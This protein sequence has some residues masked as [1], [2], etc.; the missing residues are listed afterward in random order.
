MSGP[1]GL[2]GL[3]RGTVLVVPYRPEWKTL[4]EEE[5]ALLRALLGAAALSVEHTGSTSV[6]GMDAKPIIDLLVAVADLEEAR[7]LI[8][9]LEAEGYEFRPET[10][11]PDRLFF[12]KGARELRTHH[13]SLAAAS[14]NFYR[15][16]LLFRDYLRARPAA[17][18]EYR[19]LK[20]RLAR[21]FPHDRASYTEGKSDFIKHVLETAGRR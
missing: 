3:P 10:D 8:P 18:A 11:I 1:V 7:G 13:L 15:D 19:A 14:S 12:A 2:V 5:A 9:K 6:E 4:F 16:H 17:R 20:Q 21:E